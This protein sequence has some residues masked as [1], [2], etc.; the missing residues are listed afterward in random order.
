MSLYKAKKL[1]DNQLAQ[2]Y[3]G[4]LD[5]YRQLARPSNYLTSDQIYQRLANNLHYS[6]NS[7][8]SQSTKSS[9]SD[10]PP[11]EQQK[12]YTV[13]NTFFLASPKGQGR[14]ENRPTFFWS[15]PETITYSHYPHCHCYCLSNDWFFTWYMLNSLSTYR[16]GNSPSSNDDSWTTF[17]FILLALL[18]LAF[19]VF[20]FYY[21]FH[22]TLNSME[23][24]IYNEGWLQGAITIAS[25]MAGGAAVGMLTT[26]FVAN[27]LAMVILSTG[28]VA[29]PIGLT[30]AGIVCLSIM[31]AALSTLVTNQIQNFVIKRYHCDA[32]DPYDPFRFSLTPA[33]EHHLI[34]KGID[35]IKVKC[36][37]AALRCQMGKSG[38][39]N[40]ASRLFSDKN[41]L[42]TLRKL[43]E[44][45]SKA[46]SIG[47]FI[48]DLNLDPVNHAQ[49]SGNYTASNHTN[50]RMFDSDPP[51]PYPG[52]SNVPPAY[53]PGATQSPSYV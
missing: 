47:E 21:L 17:L 36:A 18:V 14:S 39:S 11:E 33:Q 49:P 8:S 31:G 26:F 40:Y 4:L 43:K 20:A 28:I 45:K 23:R 38:V 10:L 30:I 24:F 42:I 50:F 13:L 46:V 9:L 48:F 27:P 6:L 16:V 41:D 5:D 29:N 3:V 52:N 53:N 32:L 44:G 34:L 51:P 37:L 25:M 15:L 7:A 2:F 19:T 1:T 35:P 12:L 22:Q